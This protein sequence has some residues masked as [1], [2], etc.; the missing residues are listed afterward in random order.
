MKPG[1]LYILDEKKFHV[2]TEWQPEL[3]S[4]LGLVSEDGL[5]PLFQAV[6]KETSLPLWKLSLFGPVRPSKDE[7]SP[8]HTT[9]D[10]LL[11]LIR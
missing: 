9:E 3:G 4:Q 2:K 8:F 7:V 5:V 11:Y 1:Q 10:T 6:S